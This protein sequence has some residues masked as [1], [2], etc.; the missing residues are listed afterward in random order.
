ML[1]T[2][3]AERAPSD[4]HIG[5]DENGNGNGNADGNVDER[6]PKRAKKG[7]RSHAARSASKLYA[8]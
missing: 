3:S 8:S 7:E 2:S 1:G 5:V 4:E 6:E